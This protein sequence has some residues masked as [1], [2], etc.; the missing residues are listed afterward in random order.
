MMQ[1]SSFLSRYPSCDSSTNHQL[2][3]QMAA[4]PMPVVAVPTPVAPAKWVHQH[5]HGRVPGTTY[6]FC[7][8]CWEGT[9][10]PT[11]GEVQAV[12][13]S[14]KLP[15]DFWPGVVGNKGG[16][17]SMQN[18]CISLHPELVPEGFRQHRTKAPTFDA[19]GGVDPEV[20]R[21][22]AV[23]VA[24]HDL[25]PPHLLDG[26]S[27]IKKFLDKHVP[28]TC[29]PKKLAE[30]IDQVNADILEDVRDILAGAKED[31]CQFVIQGDSWKP[32]MKRRR[33]YLAVMCSW[34]DGNFNFNEV[35]IGV[36]ALGAPRTGERYAEAFRSVLGT[37][38]LVAT[39]LLAGVSDHEGAIRKGLRLLS[40]LPLV[41]CGCHGLQLAPK[42]V[43]PDPRKRKAAD[44]EAPAPAVASDAESSSARSSGSSRRTR[45]RFQR[46][47]T[48][49]RHPCFVELW[50]R[51]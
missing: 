33:H 46:R 14:G 38:G 8:K 29:G 6:R 34:V 32:K 23:N 25:L 7:K 21:E 43:L 13:A 45:P 16:P 1:C 36:R 24:L 17:T 47:R 20:C 12:L 26:A 4:A 9:P 10:L 18:H 41:G 49:P 28:G 37:V 31:G 39:D 51:C 50:T 5:F 30:I 44:V 27:G 2:Y 11:D 48:A 42:H 35:C 3:S 22:F 19:H 40:D 15:S